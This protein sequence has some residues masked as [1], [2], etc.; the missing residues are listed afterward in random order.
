MQSLQKP[1][2]GNIFLKSGCELSC[3][4]WELNPGLL[5]HLSCLE[6]RQSPKG[7]KVFFV[8]NFKI[9]IVFYCPLCLLREA[10]DAGRWRF[11]SFLDMGSSLCPGISA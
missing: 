1:E 2:E 10:E 7:E 4:C 5:N 11:P 3:E 8:L 6:V 9:S